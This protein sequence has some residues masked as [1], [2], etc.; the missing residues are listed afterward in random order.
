VDAGATDRNGL[1]VGVDRDEFVGG[2][3]EAQ[4]VRSAV[5]A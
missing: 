2:Q 4:T 1:L 5:T 3:G